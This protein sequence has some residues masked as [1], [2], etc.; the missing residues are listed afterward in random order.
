MGE[1]ITAEMLERVWAQVCAAMEPQP[2]CI[3]VQERLISPQTK[4][5]RFRRITET[6]RVE[7][8]IPLAA[9]RYGFRD[10]WKDTHL[11]DRRRL[12]RAKRG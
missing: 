4:G 8:G 7:W 11:V 5:T 6:Q 3:V 9:C 10:F 1:T 2:D 12:K